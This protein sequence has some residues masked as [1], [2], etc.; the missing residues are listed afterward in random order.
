MPKNE[1]LDWMLANTVSP[2]NVDSK[3]LSI[4]EILAKNFMGSFDT[5]WNYY[6]SCN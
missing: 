4:A 6:N 2:E 3:V 1:I 5:S